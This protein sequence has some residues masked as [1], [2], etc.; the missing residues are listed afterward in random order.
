VFV[1]DASFRNRAD[2]GGFLEWAEFLGHRY[3]TPVPSPPKGSDVL[4][5]IDI[6][7]AR[8]VVEK[9]PEAIVILLLPPSDEIQ[10]R[11]LAER[12]DPPAQ[13]AARIETGRE[14]VRQA[15]RLA[16]YEVVNDDVNRATTEVAG[17]VE[18]ARSARLEHS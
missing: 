14:E 12:G 15:R 5:E 13:V 2:E 8:Q 6:Q 17:I 16:H 4:L 9:E 10:G 3:G 7:G 11:R 18:A 1:N